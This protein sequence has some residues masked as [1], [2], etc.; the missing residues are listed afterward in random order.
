[1]KTHST[2]MRVYPTEGGAPLLLRSAKTRLLDGRQVKT[3]NSDW[4]ASGAEN[5]VAGSR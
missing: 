3:A 2:I 5:H 1:M 4:G